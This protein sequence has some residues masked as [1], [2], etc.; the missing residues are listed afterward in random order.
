MR[1]QLFVSITRSRG[2]VYLSG[3]GDEPFYREV[4]EV[5]DAVQRNPRAPSLSFVYNRPD[6]SLDD[7][8]QL[9]LAF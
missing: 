9:S 8:A 6:R 5:V 2:W 4:S 1:N 7:E 3:T